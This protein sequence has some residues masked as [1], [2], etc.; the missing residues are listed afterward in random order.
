MTLVNLANQYVPSDRWLKN[1]EHDMYGDY[2]LLAIHAMGRR[3][4]LERPYLDIRAP[5][6]RDDPYLDADEKMLSLMNSILV[7]PP[8]PNV[9]TDAVK[10]LDPDAVRMLREIA[11]RRNKSYEKF[12]NS[13][14]RHWEEEVLKAQPFLDQLA[15]PDRTMP[16]DKRRRLRQVYWLDQ[17]PFI[18]AGT[19]L[20]K[21]PGPWIRLCRFGE[22]FERFNKAVPQRA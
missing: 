9:H 5:F 14:R 4:D 18:V 6:I 3:L 17:G 10:T 1:G 11:F 19:A 13:G 8:D 16:D 20:D 22:A 21:C 15:K 12:L 7:K 2:S